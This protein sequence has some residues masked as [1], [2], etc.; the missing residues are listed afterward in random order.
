MSSLLLLKKVF[1]YP[2]NIL[3]SI[4]SLPKWNLC[5]DFK[6]VLHVLSY[7]INMCKLYTAFSFF[8]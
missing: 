3:F 8:P 2:S 7:K 4:N 5:M 6:I 1:P